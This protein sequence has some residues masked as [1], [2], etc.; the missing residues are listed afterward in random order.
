MGYYTPAL[1]QTYEHVA[2]S[3]LL[4]LGGKLGCSALSHRNLDILPA[5]GVREIVL[6]TPTQLRTKRAVMLAELSLRN[7]IVQRRGYPAGEITACIRKQHRKL[8]AG[9]QCDS[10]VCP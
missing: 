8:F 6:Y 2:S 9:V 10:I 3:A 7:S 5:G 4:V 1:T